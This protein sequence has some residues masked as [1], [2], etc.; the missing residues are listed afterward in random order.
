MKR[1]VNI[2]KYIQDLVKISKKTLGE[3]LL[4]I[5]LFGSVVRNE[6]SKISDVDVLVVVKKYN[7]Q[8]ER[9]EQ[10]LMTLSLKHKLIFVPKGF[11][12]K[13]FLA[14]SNT[15]GMFRSTFITD[16]ESIKKWR[17]QRI[18]RVSRFMSKILAPIES[19]K[20]TIMKS[21]KVIYGID[22]FR[23]MDVK[24]PSFGEI[25]KS[26]LMNILLAICSFILLPFHRET[27]KFVY[28]AVKW[29]M[30]NYAYVSGEKISIGR[31]SQFFRKP[32]R[33]GIEH[34]MLTRMNGKL[35]P[36][37]LIYAI[38]AILKIHLTSLSK[39]KIK[40]SI[41]TYDASSKRHHP[42]IRY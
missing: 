36:G 12:G 9:L 23:D 13:L 42:Y 16:I 15:T 39:L 3:N 26:F 10:V 37:L 40:R 18:F 20:S 19:V 31:L 24:E 32:I 11:F 5:V 30:F 6:I 41:Q 35:S 33:N 25:I 8:T 34:F 22:P 29:S 14:L 21:Y 38:P 7:K 27:Y 2:K 1:T 17:F 4:S 28:E